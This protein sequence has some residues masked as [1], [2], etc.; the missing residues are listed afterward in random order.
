MGRVR[1]LMSIALIGLVACE[2]SKDSGADGDDG[3]SGD[4]FGGSDGGDGGGSGGGGEDV[5]CDADYSL[6][7]DTCVSET[8][9]C[10][11]TVFASN[12][13][14]DAALDGSNY[15]SFWAC[16]VVGFGS[17]LGPERMFEFLHPG[18]GDV[19]VSLSSPCG[20]LDLFVMRWEDGCVR[21]DYPVN[22]CEGAV[23]RGGGSITIWNNEPSRYLIV[24]DGPEG[25]TDNYAVG[26]S[27]G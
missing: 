4:G 7:A 6:D 8:L 24:V 27:C 10:G 12:L 18:T 5:D 16:Q 1:A 17:Y 11:D 9:G 26:L 14:G 15:S 25:E 21:D 19:E 3:G 22:E 13:G 23:G 20:D 2:G